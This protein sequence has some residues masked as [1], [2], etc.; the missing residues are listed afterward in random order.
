L[1]IDE[2]TNESAAI[3]LVLAGQNARPSLNPNGDTLSAYTARTGAR[4]GC[5]C[6]FTA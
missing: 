4:S 6:Q 5:C 1:Q 3:P 2:L